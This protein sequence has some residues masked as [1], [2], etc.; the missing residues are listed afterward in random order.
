MKNKTL[1]EIMNEISQW[2]D[3]VFG[4]DQ[5]TIPITHH[6]IKEVSELLQA[7][8]ELE[9]YTGYETMHLPSHPFYPYN[10]LDRKIELDAGKSIKLQHNVNDEFADCFI[11]LLDSLS[12]YGLTEYAIKVLIKKKLEINKKRKWGNLDKNG[13]IEHIKEVKK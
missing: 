6:L 13:V 12:H 4:Y 7:L 10:A 11:L 2:S 3:S 1:Q 5:R 8:K 9:T